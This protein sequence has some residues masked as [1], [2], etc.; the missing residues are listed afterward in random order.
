MVYFSTGGWI[1]NL[2]L[3]SCAR[4]GFCSPAPLQFQDTDRRNPFT[5]A[6]MSKA[7][8]MSFPQAKRVG[9]PSDSPLEKGDEGGCL[10][11]IPD[12][13]E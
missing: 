12:K 9:N 5:K 11:K 2:S 8:L 4:T 1:W 6:A 3:M 7:T 10:R 13:P